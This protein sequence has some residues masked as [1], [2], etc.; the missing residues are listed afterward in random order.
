MSRLE[1]ILKAKKSP[2]SRNLACRDVPVPTAATR[3]RHGV[4]D[5]QNCRQTC[6]LAQVLR[7]YRP[8]GKSTPVC[9]SDRLIISTGKFAS[10]AIFNNCPA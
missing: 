9:C 6:R 1:S 2:P 10:P 4:T 3:R 5:Q 7:I 8:I